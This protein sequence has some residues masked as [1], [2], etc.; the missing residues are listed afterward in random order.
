MYMSRWSNRQRAASR[1]VSLVVLVAMVFATTGIGYAA[2][3]ASIGTRRAPAAKTAVSVPTTPKTDTRAPSNATVK[4]PKVPVSA[5]V[6]KVVPGAPIA[7]ECHGWIHVYKFEDYNGNGCWDKDEPPIEGW[8]FYLRKG[9]RTSTLVTDAEGHASMQAETGTWFVSEEM[10]L[11]W[12]YV[13]PRCINLS[14]D[15]SESVYFG[16]HRWCVEK[17][18]K[19]SYPGAPVDATF[20]VIYKPC[21]GRSERVELAFDGESGMWVG[22]K[23]VLWKAPFSLEWWISGPQGDAMLGMTGRECID[24]DTD[25]V[26]EYD[27]SLEGVK[28]EDVNYNGVRD[29]GEPGL[30][31]WTIQLFSVSNGDLEVTSESPI[32]ETITGDDGAYAFTQLPPGMYYV[33]EVLK[34]GWIQTLAPEGDVE[35]GD[36]VHA[37]GLDFGN[38]RVDVTKTFEMM[39]DVVKPEVTYYAQYTVNG[40]PMTTELGPDEDPHLFVGE[41]TLKW[42]YEI[43]MVSWYAV[44]GG[45]HIW[46]GSTE[47]EILEQLETVNAFHY[48]PLVGGHKF[49]DLNGNGV[50]NEGEPGLAGWTIQLW[51]IPGQVSQDVVSPVTVADLYAETVTGEGGS[52]AFEGALPGIYYVTEVLQNGWQQ[53]LMPEG[54]FEIV[55]GTEI[56]T[57]DFGNRQ[58][59]PDLAIQK[60]VEPTLAVRGDTVAYTLVWENVG[61]YKAENYTITDDFDERYMAVV[62]PAGGVVADGKITWAFAGP[63]EPGA[64]PMTLTYTLQVLDT[65]PVDVTVVDNT[66][67]IAHPDDTD[68]TNN[69]DEAALELEP[70]A[71]FTPTNPEEPFLPFTGGDVALLLF[72]AVAS[73]GIGLV[74]RRRSA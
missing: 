14:T 7:P 40:E 60:S 53:T 69:T 38:M 37:T 41:E 47:G 63:I 66:V 21:I 32:A 19:V 49:N 5:T 56:S 1:V 8:T 28:F 43:G 48:D 31:G 27:S 71:P 33:R 46:L 30:P 6:P 4:V 17:T 58:L 15:E 44:Y 73:A 16:N 59:F 2:P 74:L 18:L 24:R 13:L 62:D 70:F 72:A 57:L 36:G 64:E 50:W 11:G 23:T 10:R 65:V 25:N 34:T 61:E 68:L 67:V 42:G 29:P 35:I 12:S 3:K 20:Y 39:L 22:T 45:E 54:T 55:N 51:R 52:Y 9:T 26:F